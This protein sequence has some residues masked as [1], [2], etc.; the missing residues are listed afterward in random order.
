MGLM[1]G[2]MKNKIIIFTLVILAAT[3]FCFGQDTE[4][5]PDDFKMLRIT[6]TKQRE[7]NEAAAQGYRVLIGTPT[8]DEEM[9]L[10]LSKDGTVAEPYKY[11]LVGTMWGGT[12]QKE[13]WNGKMRKDFKEAADAGYR[14]IPSTIISRVLG[15]A[16]EVVMIMERPPQV[17]FQYEYKVLTNMPTAQKEMR[18]ARDAGYVI[19]GMVFRADNLVAVMEREVKQ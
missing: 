9:A 11:K 7:L 19:V 6:S 10:L 12:I 2:K 1:R 13:L 16:S 8:T 14:L 4:A 3:G 18:E 5:V 17:K 15:S